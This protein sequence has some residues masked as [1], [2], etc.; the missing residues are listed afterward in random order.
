MNKVILIGRT[1]GEP[2]TNKNV[3]NISLATTEHFKADGER[4]EHT[5]WHRLV[6]FG[7]LAE[8][9]QKWVTKGMQIAIEGRL[10]TSS[11]EKDG[12]T[13]YSR[14]IIV[15]RLEMLG[16]KNVGKEPTN[17]HPYEEEKNDLPF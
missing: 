16:G 13:R 9:A 14:D 11:Y 15:D 8:T 4:K 3:T 12:E 6:L 10:R 2:T 5:E 1:G 7:K 17:P